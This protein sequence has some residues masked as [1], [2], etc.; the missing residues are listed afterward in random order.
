LYTP[1]HL[2]KYL[3]NTYRYTSILFCIMSELQVQIA[4][5]V[6]T[7]S[8]SSDS[9]ITAVDET[10]FDSTKTL[11][12]APGPITSINLDLDLAKPASPPVA[13]TN[14]DL[15]ALTTSL[16]TLFRA[17]TSSFPPLKIVGLIGSTDK[18]CRAYARTV[19]KQCTSLG[20]IF[21]RRDLCVGINGEEVVP[22]FE[23]AKGAMKEINR[24][25]GVDGL[26]VFTPIF[27]GEE[28][29]PFHVRSRFL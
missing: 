19:E 12:L 25:E 10:P 11:A 8:Y 7:S 15:K 27:G 14:L 2:T 23:G 1:S 17:S 16:E 29:S 3:F 21:E 13:I 4:R 28:V 26:I 5:P 22:S 20:V 18:G 6:I 9:V 24:M